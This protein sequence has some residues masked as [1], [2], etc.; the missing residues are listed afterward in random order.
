MTRKG[1]TTRIDD[2]KKKIK[3]PSKRHFD[4]NTFQT[5]I[6]GDEKH[7]LV[8]RQFTT[9]ILHESAALCSKIRHISAFPRCAHSASFVPSS[10]D[11][12]KNMIRKHVAVKTL[13]HSKLIEI[14]SWSC[15]RICS[16]TKFSKVLLFTFRMFSRALFKLASI[17][18][19]SAL[20][21]KM[22][23]VRS[24]SLKLNTACTSRALDVKLEVLAIRPFSST[25]V[26]TFAFSGSFEMRFN[27]IQY[28]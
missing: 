9:S 5:F 17:L 2:S 1:W 20:R 26:C 4:A 19:Q 3:H 7:T 8:S 12:K 27:R 18:N 6:E 22:L 10:F 25:F 23:P 15:G 28:H 14:T 11:K 13:S 21:S 16:F 24:C